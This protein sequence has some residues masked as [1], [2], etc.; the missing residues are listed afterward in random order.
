MLPFNGSENGA[1]A[2]RVP[3][4]A[5][6]SSF[7]RADPVGGA[8]LLLPQRRCAGILDDVAC[9]S[10]WSAPSSRPPSPPTRGL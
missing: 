3:E 5:S 1:G 8:L 6:V 7:A 10:T 9:P 2:D 4:G